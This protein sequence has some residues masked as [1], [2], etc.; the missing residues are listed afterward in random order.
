MEQNGTEHGT[1]A[2]VMERNAEQDPRSFGFRRSVL[3]VLTNSRL[4]FF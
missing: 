1:G 3:T 2:H 4:V